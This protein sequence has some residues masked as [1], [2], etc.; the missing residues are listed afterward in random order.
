MRKFPLA[1]SFSA[2]WL[3]ILGTTQ[4]DAISNKIYRFLSDATG[5]I[6]TNNF[7]LRIMANDPS[8]LDVIARLMP[9]LSTRQIIITIAD[10]IVR[11]KKQGM[12]FSEENHYFR[13][14]CLN[15]R[16]FATI[17]LVRAFW[18]CSIE[19]SMPKEF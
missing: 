10:K 3:S 17:R 14:R 13:F 11:R 5:R 16:V 6:G 19:R 7:P 8:S 12:F 18:L 2:S 9:S 15:V 1:F 4:R